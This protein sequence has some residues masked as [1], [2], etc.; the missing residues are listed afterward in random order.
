MISLQ[1]SPSFHWPVAPW[2]CTVTASC[3]VYGLNPV[4][5]APADVDMLLLSLSREH[6]DLGSDSESWLFRG[7]VY[8]A[9]AKSAAR[10]RITSCENT[11]LTCVIFIDIELFILGTYYF[12]Y[13]HIITRY[14]VSSSRD[15]FRATLGSLI[16]MMSD[17]IILLILELIWARIGIGKTVKTV[18]WSNVDTCFKTL[19]KKYNF[20][21]HLCGGVRTAKEGVCLIC[22]DV[23]K[24]KCKW[25]ACHHSFI[26]DG[27]SILSKNIFV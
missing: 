1:H 13:V 15:A 4:P 9:S 24:C 7:I 16:R 14:I 26:S 20:I 21:I 22:L 3:P 17:F 11:T 18:R 27:K 12:R 10:F 19:P 6:G 25:H 23:S 5:T 8:S 2:S